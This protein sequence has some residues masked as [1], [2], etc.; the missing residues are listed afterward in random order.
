MFSLIPMIRILVF[1]GFISLTNLLSAQNAPERSSPFLP[2]GNIFSAT[3]VDPNSL[4]LRGLLT[5]SKGTRFCIFDPNSKKSTWLSVGEPHEIFTIESAD[6]TT[7]TIVIQIQGRQVTLAMSDSKVAS[8]SISV[9]E[10]PALTKV[11]LNPTPQDEQRR[12]QA[13]TEEI[14]RRRQLRE[15]QNQ[16]QIPLRN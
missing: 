4:Q 7:G 16:F 3:D 9:G 12:L 11:V 8:N 1:W 13:I 6:R 5:T 10:S 2:Q 15:Q 14:T